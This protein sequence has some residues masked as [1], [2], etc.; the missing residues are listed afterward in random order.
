LSHLTVPGLGIAGCG[1]TDVVAVCSFAEPFAGG[2]GLALQAKAN[3]TRGRMENTSDVERANG[4]MLFRERIHDTLRSMSM[5]PSK[6][7]DEA[8]RMPVEARARL[9]AELL[10]SLDED[11]DLDGAEYEAAWSSEIAERLREVEV[12]EVQTVPWSDARKRIVRED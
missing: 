7:R 4:V 3:V 12:G 1:V 11:E 6:L 9:A 5:D 10:R 8:L 2:A